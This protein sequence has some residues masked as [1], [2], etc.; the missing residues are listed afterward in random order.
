MI[1]AIKA[2]NLV[3]VLIRETQTGSNKNHSYQQFTNSAHPRP[4]RNLL[5]YPAPST[6]HATHQRGLNIPTTSSVNPFQHFLGILKP[7]KRRKK[8]SLI[9]FVS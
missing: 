5:D 1:L 6:Q 3:M 2:F 7:A 9:R 8:Q 4:Q